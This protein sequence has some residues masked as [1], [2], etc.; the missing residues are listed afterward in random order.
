MLIKFANALNWLLCLIVTEETSIVKKKGT[1][2]MRAELKLFGC[3]IRDEFLK[4]SDVC[5]KE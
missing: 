5:F 3:K 4:A 1:Y 2:Y